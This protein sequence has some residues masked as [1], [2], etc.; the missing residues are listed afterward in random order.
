MI[1]QQLLL[2]NSCL[3]G[4]ECDQNSE[5]GNRPQLRSTQSCLRADTIGGHLQTILATCNHPR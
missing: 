4:N 1:P 3:K 2:E 5:F